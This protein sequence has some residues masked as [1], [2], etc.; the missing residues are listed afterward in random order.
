LQDK[1]TNL[2]LNSINLESELNK[3]KSNS[4]ELTE[5]LD[6]LKTE[7]ELA[8]KEHSLNLNNLKDLVFVSTIKRCISAIKSSLNLFEDPVLLNCKNGSEYLLNRM[9]P[10]S[11]LL[12]QMLNFY[13]KFIQTHT[14]TDYS[15]LL[16]DINTFTTFITDC[17]INGKITSL[18]AAD[19]DQGESLA[20]LCRS[21]G[22]SSISLLEKLELKKSLS[23]ESDEKYLIELGDKI[24]KILYELLPKVH[25]INKQEIGDLIDQEMHNTSEAIEAAVAKLEVKK[26]TFISVFLFLIIF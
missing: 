18:T 12:T 15:T 24:I 2:L 16:N 26:L 17:V 3:L 1:C 23:T 4:S 8:E 25:D 9:Q 5:K 20:E 21:F 14:D 22:Q 11:E 19:L 10:F 13:E 7:K 6:E